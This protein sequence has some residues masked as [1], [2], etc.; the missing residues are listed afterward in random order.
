MLASVI[1]IDDLNRAWKVGLGQISFRPI[2]DHHLGY[3]AA[4]ASIPGLQEDALAELSAVS[5][6]PV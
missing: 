2:A 6:A 1:Q 3:G 5:M 4:P